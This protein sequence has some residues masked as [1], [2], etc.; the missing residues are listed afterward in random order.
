MSS[1]MVIS[2][3]IAGWFSLLAVV[4][5]I[6]GAGATLASP[7][8]QWRELGDPIRAAQVLVW[9]S[10]RGRALMFGGDRDF[11]TPTASSWQL[12]RM[13]QPH[14]EPLAT[15]GDVPP[16]RSGCSAV[17]DSLRDRVLLF[18]GR[19]AYPGP[20]SNELWELR[21]SNLPEWTRLETGGDPMPSARF[22]ASVILDARDRLILF[23]G[24]GD[25]MADS[26]I[27]ILP[28]AEA[29]LNWQVVA[30]P[31]PGPGPRARH[32]AAYSSR[33]SR[34]V[35]FGGDRHVLSGNVLDDYPIRPA[36]T[37]E[38]ALDEPIHWVRGASAPSDSVPLPEVG[39]P[40]VADATGTSAWLIPG[41]EGFGWEDPS[42]WRYDFLTR[43]WRR[44]S[45][46]SG[47]PGLRVGAAACVGRPSDNV[48]VQGGGRWSQGGDPAGGTGSAVWSFA[49]GSVPSWSPEVASPAVSGSP[50]PDPRAHFDA[51]TRRIFTW[52]VDGV[53]TRDVAGDGAWRLNA[54]SAGECPPYFNAMSVIDPLRR[55]LLVFGGRDDSS[56][57]PANR[58]WSWSLDGPSGWTS[59][60][61]DGDAPRG[62]WGTQC[63]Y[64][65]IQDRVLVL[66]SSGSG[67]APMVPLDTISVLQLGGTAPR[68]A[69]L[70]TEGGPPPFRSDAGVLVDDERGR[71]VLSG[72]LIPGGD[73]S[74]ARDLWTLSLGERARWAERIFPSF[75]TVPYA[76][77]GL[78]IDPTLDRL[79]LIGGEGLAFLDFG[80]SNMVRSTSL[81]DPT[82]WSDLDPERVSPMRGAGVAFFDAAAD[83]MLWWNG[84][85]LWEL[86]WPLATPLPYGPATITSEA[87][88]VFVRWP[89]S[90]SGPYL[91]DVERSVDGGRSWQRLQSVAAQ[92]GGS[93]AFLDSLP[94]ASGTLVY[95]A[96]I[97]RGG[98]LHVLGTASMMLART[99]PPAFAVAPLRPNPAADEV[100][101]EFA[102]PVNADVTAELFDL[103][104]R[105]V[106]STLHRSVGAGIGPVA[107][108][109]PL[110]RGLVPGVYLVR[111]SDGTHRVTMRLAVVR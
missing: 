95:R 97:E 4:G 46:G 25:G 83:R 12:I 62:T 44:A 103:A 78:A 13:P 43:S 45:S 11:G 7:A 18:G 57:V 27:W 52:N 76:R 8:V 17:Y 108:A 26:A 109:M 55:R 24:D 42:V 36:A 51:V 71:L 35:V 48:I 21:L 77:F 14:W 32:G 3:P 99:P 1:V 58:L 74:H 100:V 80:Q 106:G 10:R 30:L 28:L 22:G 34:M 91:A 60:V 40:L 47:G 105:R 39:G 50:A 68:W 37:W 33:T 70:P 63:A 56:P 54:V 92:S 85:T 94:P 61:I 65:P 67:T 49:T 79:V 69:K 87:G 81:D 29:P 75:E 90:A 86:T 20:S 89:G 88:R 64:D 73:G 5:L 16:P 19:G 110:T 72:G 93:L 84:N 82:R 101:I 98:S 53:W 107:L 111:V 31:G 41:D 96:V 104:G 102:S 59:A 66:P 23:G 38:L 2:R 15:Q 9:D 6:S